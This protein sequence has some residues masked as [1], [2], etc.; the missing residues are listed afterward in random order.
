MDADKLV[1]VVN[2]P[3]VVFIGGP[4]NQERTGNMQGDLGPE[5]LVDLIR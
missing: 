3:P 5:I 2:I 1:M 4:I